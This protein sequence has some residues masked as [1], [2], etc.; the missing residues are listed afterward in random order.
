MPK[1]VEKIAKS[2]SQQQQ[3][4]EQRQEP[5]KNFN[6]KNLKLDITIPNGQTNSQPM[7]IPSHTVMAP[8][9]V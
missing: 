9:H 1:F 3:E 8:S 2:H 6:R 7:I 4:E 5:K